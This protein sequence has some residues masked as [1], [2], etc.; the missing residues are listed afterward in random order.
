[1]NEEREA[2]EKRSRSDLGIIRPRESFYRIVN[3]NAFPNHK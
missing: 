3:E 1:M 2:I